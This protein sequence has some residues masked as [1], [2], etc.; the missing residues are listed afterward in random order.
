MEKLIP[1]LIEQEV[2]YKTAIKMAEILS[3]DGYL[4]SAIDIYDSLVCELDF[5]LEEN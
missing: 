3:N 4:D 2:N 5:V 1:I